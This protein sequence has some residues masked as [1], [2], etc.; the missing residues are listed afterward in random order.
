MGERVG[1]AAA[2]LLGLTALG[3]AALWSGNHGNHPSYAAMSHPW[4]EQYQ[5]PC[6]TGLLVVANGFF[7]FADQRRGAP[8]PTLFVPYWPLI[9]LAAVWPVWYGRRQ[10]LERARRRHHFQ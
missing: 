6:D 1:M 8:A 10:L 3:L 4:D 5:P 2:V 7:L 9:L